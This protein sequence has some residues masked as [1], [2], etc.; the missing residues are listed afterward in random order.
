MTIKREFEGIEKFEA[1]CGAVST[2]NTIVENG[3]AD[4]FDR[5][6]EEIFPD[7]CTETELNDF[8]WFDDDTIFEMLGISEDEEQDED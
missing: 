5:L 7:G 4:E 1:W 3:K 8:L 2:K 6:I